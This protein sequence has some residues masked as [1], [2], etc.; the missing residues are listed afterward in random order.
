MKVV[1][2]YKETIRNYSSNNA[3]SLFFLAPLPACNQPRQTLGHSESISCI[4]VKLKLTRLLLLLLP[5]AAFSVRHTPF[6]SPSHKYVITEEESN[7]E[8]QACTIYIT[9]LYL[10]N[11]RTGKTKDKES[12]KRKRNRPISPCY[13]NKSS[14]TNR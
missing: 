4:R 5:T 9:F 1:C 3:A 13:Y 7:L 8:S 6:R 14:N 2:I 12:V 10:R 11:S